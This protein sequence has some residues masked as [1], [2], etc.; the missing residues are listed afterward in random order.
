MT[1]Q[2]SGSPFDLNGMAV[3]GGMKKVFIAEDMQVP[4]GHYAVLRM[5]DNKD[6]ADSFVSFC[7]SKLVA[8]LYFVGITASM[9][10]IENW[11]FVP[12][13]GAFDHIFT[14]E[15][16]YKKYNLTDE[17]IAIIESVIKERK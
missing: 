5:F 7:A 10:V 13:P 3:G 1:S 15:E 14:D 6:E 17:E 2:G 11:R 4:Q 8:F 12:D 9:D 16:L